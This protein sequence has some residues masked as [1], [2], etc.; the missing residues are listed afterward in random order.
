VFKVWI[1]GV[2]QY[3]S[4]DVTI[5]Q[6]ATVSISKNIYVGSQTVLNSI[7]GYIEDVLVTD[8][9]FTEN[10]IDTHYG[11]VYSIENTLTN[12]KYIGKKLFWSAKTKQVNKKKKRYKAPSDWQDYYGSN[13]VLKKDIA[14]FGKENFTRTILHLCVSK[15]E[16][17]YLEAKEQFV[18]GVIESA[19][20]Y[21]TWIMVRVR[22]T[23]I[24]NYIERT[25]NERNIRKNEG[26]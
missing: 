4:G 18:N 3:F 11:F 1:D 15:G 26:S 23:H 17:S 22:D 25:K 19:D 20:Y 2:L 8:S 6:I 24:K 5:P 16:C 13:E 21:N 7:G 9:L 14:E 12:R 10:D